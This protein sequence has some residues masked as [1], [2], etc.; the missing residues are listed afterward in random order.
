VK[1]VTKHNANDM[2]RCVAASERRSRDMIYLLGEYMK[3]EHQKAIAQAWSEMNA[4]R[5]RDG[6]PYQFDG[7]QS[8]VTQEHWDSVMDGLNQILV[9][10]TGKAAWL[11]PSLHT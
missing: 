4:I 11:H 8:D 10:E 7:T 6:V 1:I 9:D 5:A 2:R 3:K